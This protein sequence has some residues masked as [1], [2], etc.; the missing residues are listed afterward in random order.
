[1]SLELVGQMGAAIVLAIIGGA[2]VSAFGRGYWERLNKKVDDSEKEIK[3]LR[4]DNIAKLDNKID[5][6]HSE[7]S[8]KLDKDIEK[9]DEKID[10]HIKDDK[11]QQILTELKGLSGMVSKLDDKVGHW[12]EETS[13]QG[14]AIKNNSDFNR[15]L[16]GSHQTLRES[17]QKLRE[18]THSK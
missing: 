7:L 16:Y 4:E 3:R 10:N 14:E 18:E 17:V 8:K 11:S 15:N 1:M 5:N 13:R 9:L 6:N 2:V 12:R